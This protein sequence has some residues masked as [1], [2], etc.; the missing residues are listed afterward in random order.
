M[1]A[2][3]MMIRDSLTSISLM[4]LMIRAVIP[5]DVATIAAPMNMA[6]FM[7][8]PPTARTS[9]RPA[10]KGRMTPSKAQSIAALPDPNR[11]FT[12]VSNPTENSRNIT[13]NSASV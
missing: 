10:T 6:Q 13:P 9:A 4:S 2:A 3:A 11:S 5:T 1:T 8:Y 12:L 7:S